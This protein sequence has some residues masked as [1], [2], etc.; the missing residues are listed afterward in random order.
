MNLPIID[1]Q[2]CK[3]KLREKLWTHPEYWAEQKLH[4]CRYLLYSDGRLLSR[5][6]SVDGSGYVDKIDRVPHFSEFAKKLP[7]GTILDGE[8]VSH[9]FGT[10]KDVTSILGSLPRLA[11][12]KQNERGWLQYRIF[13]IPFYRGKDYRAHTL[14]FRRIALKQLIDSLDDNPLFTLNKRIYKNKKEFCESIWEKG[15]EG[16]VL[17]WEGAT[18]GEQKYWIKAKKEDTFD[19]FVIGFKDAKE[20]S[21]KVD[22]TVS[23]TKY[24]ERGWIGGIEIG[25]YIKKGGKLVEIPVGSCSGISEKL[26]EKITN[27]KKKYLGRVLEVEA[28]SQHADTGKF[29]HPRFSRWRDDKSKEECIWK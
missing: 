13:D 20:I 17:K 2:K 5:H 29:E 11:I 1:P 16:V 21:T 26:R 28:Q 15:G 19:V 6:N 3:G 14:R 10:V 12:Q 18:Y 9:D 27:N 4:G 25:M 8:V 22:G 24:A 23:A 7:E